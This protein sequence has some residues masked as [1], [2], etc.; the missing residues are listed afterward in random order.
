MTR[1][2]GCGIVRAVPRAHALLLENIHT[3]AHEEFARQGVAVQTRAGGLREAELIEALAAVPGAERPFSHF[4][5]VRG[6]VR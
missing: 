3:S 6:V 2:R 1:R 5:P 4:T